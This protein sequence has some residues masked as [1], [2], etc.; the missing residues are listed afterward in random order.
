MKAIKPMTTLLYWSPLFI[1]FFLFSPMSWAQSQLSVY[2]ESPNSGNTVH[3]GCGDPFIVVHRNNFPDNVSVGFNIFF[4]GTAAQEVD[5]VV[6]EALWVDV[7]LD[8]GVEQIHIPL[9]VIADGIIEGIETLEILVSPQCVGCISTSLTIF[10]QDPLD[11]LIVEPV[12]TIAICPSDTLI[13]H[14]ELINDFV[15]IDYLW[16]DGSTLPFYID[17]N[18]STGVVS[19]LLEDACGTSIEVDYFIVAAGV[20]ATLTEEQVIACGDLSTAEMPIYFTGPG[21]YEL[22]FSIDGVLSDTLFGITENPFLLPTRSEGIYQIQ[23]ISGAGCGGVFTGQSELVLH[24]FEV[25]FAIDTV[26]CYGGS[27]GSASI[28]LIAGVEPYSVWWEN[29]EQGNHIDGLEEGYYPVTLTDVIGCVFEDSVYVPENAPISF[30]TNITAVPNCY[31]DVGGA[32]IVDF[33]CESYSYEWS[34]PSADGMSIVGLGEGTYYVTVTNDLGCQVTTPISLVGDYEPPALFIDGPDTLNC[35]NL[36][37]DL[38]LPGI[39]ASTHVFEWTTD[40]GTILGLPDDPSITITSAGTYDVW[41]QNVV[42]GCIDSTSLTVEEDIEYPV[43]RIEVLDTID[44]YNN[45]VTLY[46]EGSSSGPAFQYTWTTFD[47]ALEGEN[48]NLNAFATQGGL[49]T[50]SVLN[51]Q[52]NCASTL[53]LWVDDIQDSPSI[54]LSVDDLLT[55][56]NEAVVVSSLGS[57]QGE[58]FLYSWSTNTGQ[59]ISN[60]AAPSLQVQLP[61]DYTLNILDLEN[62]CSISSSVTV[63]LDQET[64]ILS[65]NELEQLNCSNSV[66]SILGQYAG[67]TTELNWTWSSEEDQPFIVSGLGVEVNLIGTYTIDLLDIGNGCMNTYSFEV[68]EDYEAPMIEMEDSFVLNCNLPVVQIHLENDP[69]SSIISWTNPSGAIIGDEINS[70]EIL[71]GGIYQVEVHDV[72]NGCSSIESFEVIDHRLMDMIVDIDQPICSNPL[73]Q[74]EILQVNGSIGPFVYSINDTWSTESTFESLLP[75]LYE[76]SVEDSYGC[77]ISEFSEIQEVQIP[78]IELV[79]QQIIEAGSSYQVD[80]SLNIDEQGISQVQWFPDY[81][82]SCTDCLNP[83][84]SPETQTTYYVEIETVEG[85]VVEHD[86]MIVV[87]DDRSLF[88]PNIFTPNG[89]GQNDRFILYAS[90]DYIDLRAFKIY[91]RWGELVFT[92][93]QSMLNDPASGW[94]GTFRNALAPNAVYTWFAE[95]QDK[96]GAWE[97]IKGDVTLYRE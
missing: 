74:I 44:C 52:N 65:F 67:D 8:P 31:D 25:A 20:S 9:N 12:D 45:G 75:G 55:C 10:I 86:I 88:I 5:Y 57:D 39:Q 41:V 50:L 61:G 85:C 77:L 37:D 17:P 1:L 59:V 43:V 18:P 71:E 87:R 89:D 21:P 2:L 34:E 62:G 3:E 33:E 13:I 24:P 66:V 26:T 94:D 36:I 38:T 73:G 16:S 63:E 35:A 14:P 46:G 58:N 81:A 76:V 7:T 4:A 48:T 53:D 72:N 69:N 84:L 78:S 28:S 97:V 90:E 32:I 42:N 95:I 11:G 29:G 82:I 51:I 15:A 27:D 79:D 56:S 70:P 64:P 6:E 30:S 22:V 93:D 80:L 47:G 83:I 68:T 40:N 91:D 19:L 96:R 92:G 49:Y 60:P 54:N 23:Y